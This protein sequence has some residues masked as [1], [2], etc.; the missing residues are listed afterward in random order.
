MQ[1]FNGHFY[2]VEIKGKYIHPPIYAIYE[3]VCRSEMINNQ[4]HHFITKSK[5]NKKRKQKK[6]QVIKP[7]KLVL[8]VRDPDHETNISMIDLEVSNQVKFLFLFFQEPY[9]YIRMVTQ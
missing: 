2:Y 6:Q 1:L 9:K 7:I 3:G 4:T 5:K 8:K